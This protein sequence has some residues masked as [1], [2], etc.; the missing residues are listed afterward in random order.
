MPIILLF[1]FGFAARAGDWTEDFLLRRFQDQNPIELESKA[2]IAIAGAETRAR[3]L[4]ANPSVNV[5]REGAGRTEFYQAAQS[6]PLNGRIGLLRQAG[7]EQSAV[8]AAEGKDVF[9]RARCS[10]R[11]AFYRLVAGQLRVAAWTDSL[12][13]IDQ[14]IGVLQVREQTGEGS[15]FDRLRAERERAELSALSGQLR[16]DIDLIRGEVLSLLPLGEAFQMASGSL[17]T[18]KPAFS[19]D[20]ARL[21]AFR[22]RADLEG[23]RLRQDVLRSEQRAAERLRIPDP[24]V[25]GGFKRAD[26]GLPRLETGPVLGVSLSIPLF[27]QGQAEVSRY[28]AEQQRSRAR[29]EQLQRRTAAFVDAAWQS[30]ER[31]RA[32]SDSYSTASVT[33]L[34]SIARIAYAEGEI[35]ILQLLDAYRTARESQLRKIDLESNAKQAQILLEQQLGEELP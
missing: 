17:A 6:L 1:C 29:L 24:I 9:W 34:I 28:A 30:Y 14:I 22:N 5:T 27:N 8:I 12:Q 16:A 21:R 32:V 15:R 33:E 13:Q 7:I 19:V 26:A 20:E 31:H 2:R 35:G 18:R 3:T 4:W 10:L 11:S 23:E 25:N